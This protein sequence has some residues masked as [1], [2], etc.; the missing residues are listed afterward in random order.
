MNCRSSF[1]FF[2]QFSTSVILLFNVVDFFILAFPQTLS[3]LHAF[4]SWNCIFSSTLLKIST[5]IFFFFTFFL[6]IPF[7]PHE[8]FYFSAM[9]LHKKEDEPNK[10]AF[11]FNQLDYSITKNRLNR[12]IVYLYSC[13]W[14]FELKE[15]K[16]WVLMF[17]SWDEFLL[18]N[19]SH[20]LRE[21][22]Y[23]CWVLRLEWYFEEFYITLTNSAGFT[24]W[25][26]IQ[27]MTCSAY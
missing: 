10:V 17:F 3:Y 12:L 8:F 25:S 20:L 18:H 24:L 1:N 14:S 23:V 15:K 4:S 6:Y 11:L 13:R 22:Y 5:Q 7:Y 27:S 2:A 21:D 26:F 9:R 16:E 19:V